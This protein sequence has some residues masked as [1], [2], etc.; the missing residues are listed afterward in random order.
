MGGEICFADKQDEAARSKGSTRCENA[1]RR[2]ETPVGASGFFE[3]SASM[4]V[5]I[6]I[7]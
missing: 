7:C 4:A 6:D 1:A 5:F 2:T 3:I